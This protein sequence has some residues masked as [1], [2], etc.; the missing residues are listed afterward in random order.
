MG[1][2]YGPLRKRRGSH[3]AFDREEGFTDQ[4]GTKPAMEKDGCVFLYYWSNLRSQC[5]Q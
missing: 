3:M 1:E 2:A 5:T 4:S